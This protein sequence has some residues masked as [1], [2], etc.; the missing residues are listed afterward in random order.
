MWSSLTVLLLATSALGSPLA[1]RSAASYAGLASIDVF[2][3]P[4][5][6]V[7]TVLFPDATVVGFPSPTATGA[8]ALLI[9]TA[10]VFT[11]K[12][13]LTLPFG[14]RRPVRR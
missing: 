12:T 10:L 6:T 2:P 9:A 3:P 1:K 5:A 4:S 14:G 11:K 8:E 7:D 13:D